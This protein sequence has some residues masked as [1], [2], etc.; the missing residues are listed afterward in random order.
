[1]AKAQS[2]IPAGLHTVTPH[3]IHDNAAEAIEWYTRALGAQEVSPRAIG[4]DG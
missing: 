1:M 3:L 4:P 2:A